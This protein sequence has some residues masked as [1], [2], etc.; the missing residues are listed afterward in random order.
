MSVGN[1]RTPWLVWCEKQ[2]NE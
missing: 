2:G 1:M